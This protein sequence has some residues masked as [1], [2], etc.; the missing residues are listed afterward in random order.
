MSPS[1]SSD[2]SILGQ[3]RAHAE[4]SQQQQ[5]Q[6]FD[7]A[8]LQNVASTLQSFQHFLPNTQ[9]L[10]LNFGGQ[11]PLIE[12]S[13]APNNTKTKRANKSDEYSSSSA[14]STSSADF[15]KE[16]RD[17]YHQDASAFANGKKQLYNKSKGIGGDSGKLKASNGAFEPTFDGRYLLAASGNVDHPLNLS[18]NQKKQRKSKYDI[19]RF[20]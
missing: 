19:S 7:P 10:N 18:L 8:L 11:S 2:E 4:L 14:S 16:K 5:Q 17:F 1:T 20:Q 9:S 6:H 12:S 15:D 13:L 3:M